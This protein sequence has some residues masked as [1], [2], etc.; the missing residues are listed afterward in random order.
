VKFIVEMVRPGATRADSRCD[1]ISEA[2]ASLDIGD[3]TEQMFQDG[4]TQPLAAALGRLL[5]PPP[6]R[7]VELA[8]SGDPD[9]EF[10]DGEVDTTSE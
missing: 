4:D 7:L 8:R 9:G 3:D 5:P 2:E 1:T 10:S 6:P